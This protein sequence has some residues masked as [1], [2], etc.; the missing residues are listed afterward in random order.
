MLKLRSH[1]VN[2]KNHFQNFA[3]FSHFTSIAIRCSSTR[4][5]H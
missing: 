4:Y 1:P 2:P 5:G 3:S